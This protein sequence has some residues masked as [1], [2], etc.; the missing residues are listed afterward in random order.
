MNGTAVLIV[1]VA[2]RYGR[3][4]AGLITALYSNRGFLPTS[5]PPQLTRSTY[6]APLLSTL[7]VVSGS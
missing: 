4:V 3:L 7:T 2:D 1:T 5:A 6:G